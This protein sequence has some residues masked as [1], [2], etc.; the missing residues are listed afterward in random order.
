MIIVN[1]CGYDYRHPAGF[2]LLRLHGS[3]DYL[4]LLIRTAA[5]FE[6][7]GTCLD[8]PPNTAVLYQKTAHVHYGCRDHVFDND[9]IH[10]DIT[11]EESLLESLDIPFDQ[12]F[13]LP[14]IL[15]L[16][17]YVRLIALERFAPRRQQEKILDPL[18]HA[19]LYSLSAQYHAG[20]DDRFENRYFV[21]LH[22][23][24][25]DIRN[26]PYKKWDVSA[27]AK[28]A[29]LSLTH[30]QRL[31]KGFF[32]TTCIQDIIQ[33]RIRSAQF[34]LRTTDM[35]IQ[36]LA[37]F[38]GYESELHFMRQFKKYTGLTPSQYRKRHL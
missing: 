8:T 12:P 26:A 19:L 6:I 20:Q 35:T 4:L 34:Y 38:C 31:Y 9:W 24:R 14:D 1:N 27:I 30:F 11:G 17:E 37:A 3:G 25:M 7:D 10:F 15:P 18:M 16:S 29:H 33:A 5:F 32:G 21:P 2:D 23:I 22:Q 28:S 13:T 36:A